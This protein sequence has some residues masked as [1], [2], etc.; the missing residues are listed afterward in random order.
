MGEIAE[1]LADRVILTDD[2]PR[3]EAG[4]EI[5]AHILSGMS[6]PG[7][8][9]VL[10]DRADAIA[11]AVTSAEPGDVILIAGKG[12]ETYQESNGARSIFSDANHVRLG[13]KSR[14]ERGA[15]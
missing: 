5:V 2:N 1:Q 13:L 4:D 3:N 8:A 15:T 6:D 7:E 9:L 12:H 14:E 11:H 10:R